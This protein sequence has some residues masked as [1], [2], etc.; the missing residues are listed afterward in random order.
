MKTHAIQEATRPVQRIE[1]KAREQHA[2]TAN[3]S[4]AHKARIEA[5]IEALKT[6]MRAA[7]RNARRNSGDQETA[8]IS[9]LEAQLAA[10][11]GELAGARGSR[12]YTTQAATVEKLGELLT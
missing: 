2:L 10:K 8:S 5:E 4:E 7:A 3:E 12:R 6:D 11:N 9:E 1:A